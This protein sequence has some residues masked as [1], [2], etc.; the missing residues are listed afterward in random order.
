VAVGFILAAK[1]ILR[2]SEI[3]GAEQQQV[4][5][6]VLIGTMTS[7]GWALTVALVVRQLLAG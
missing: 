2:H 1:G 5:E 6:Y 4:A 3:S 7:L